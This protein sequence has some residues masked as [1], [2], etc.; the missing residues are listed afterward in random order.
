MC[1][2]LERMSK[3]EY[4]DFYKTSFE[5]HVEE[6]IREEALSREVAESESHN[7]LQ[8][9]LPDG[10]DTADNFLYSI[11]LEGDTVGYIWFLTEMN[12]AV[13]QAFICDFLIYEKYRG[14]GYGHAVLSKME[15]LAQDYLCQESVLFVE[16]ENIKARKL[17]EKSGYQIIKNHDYGFYMK[18]KL[19]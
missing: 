13:K 18:K 2:C 10:L 1:I 16:E 9:M 11:K 12:E 7:E 15:E 8:G 6:L 3:E 4:L 19:D 17:Y 14:N 5:S